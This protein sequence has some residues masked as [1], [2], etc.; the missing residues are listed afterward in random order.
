ML[1]HSRRSSRPAHADRGLFSR[2][3]LQMA[4]GPAKRRNPCS[5]VPAYRLIR[6]VE[7]SASWLGYMKE[8]R[9][10]SPVPPPLRTEYGA[11]H[12]LIP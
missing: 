7:A 11:L 3:L 4:L 12:L 2:M 9:A 1:L 5:S 8:S 10:L 6:K